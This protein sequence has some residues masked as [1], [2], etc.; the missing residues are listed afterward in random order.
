VLVR[1]QN[2]D[3]AGTLD[4][5]LR[6]GRLRAIHH[7]VYCHPEQIT[8]VDVRIR[9]AA[10]W[11]GP[12]SVVTG[13]SAARLTF[14]PALVPADITLAQPTT[15]RRARP[16]I[17]FERRSVPPELVVRRRSVAVTHPCLTAVDMAVGEK[18][19]AAIDQ[20]LRT[21]AA[22][23]AQMWEAL[24][25]TPNRPGNELRRQV[26][27]DS[28]DQPWSEAEREAH[29]QLRRAGIKGWVANARVLDYYVDIL[30]RRERL[31]LEVDGWEAHGT[32]QAFED[33]RKRRNRLQLAGYTVLNF[34]WRQ[35]IDE[36][37]WVMACI[38]EA[39]GC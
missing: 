36:P 28:L 11:A 15:C 38:R 4:R 16:G 22:T 23:L 33:D 12:M 3:I 18:G 5:W 26:L 19:G 14:W 24:R 10:A 13:P 9:A 20:A 27:E 7:G 34:T 35:L 39:L 8:D 6:T 21:R 31:V 25:L 1:G 2:A 30:F 29:R 32:R 37:D 17:R